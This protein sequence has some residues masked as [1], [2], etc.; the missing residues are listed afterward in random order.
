MKYVVL[1]LAVLVISASA[2]VAHDV[3][4][5][6]GAKGMSAHATVAAACETASRKAGSNLVAMLGGG[7]L[8]SVSTGMCICSEQGSARLRPSGT[9]LMNMKRWRKWKNKAWGRTRARVSW[10]CSDAADT[11]RNISGGFT[12][13]RVPVKLPGQM[14]TVL[15]APDV[16][17]RRVLG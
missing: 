3:A 15:V 9:W 4:A 12:L 5:A 17:M 13:N 2:A 10:R 11:R 6:Y 1:I 14:L 8:A 7:A 16:E